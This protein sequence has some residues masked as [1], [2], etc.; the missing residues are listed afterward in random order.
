MLT[1]KEK[2]KVAEAAESPFILHLSVVLIVVMTNE[3]ARSLRFYLQANQLPFYELSV[4][5]PNM[6]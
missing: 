5:T 6:E 2:K 1:Q 4:P 3:A